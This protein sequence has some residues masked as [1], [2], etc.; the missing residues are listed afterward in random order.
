MHLWVKP[1][2]GTKCTNSSHTITGKKDGFPDE[3]TSDYQFDRQAV[4]H[5]VRGSATDDDPRV[6]GSIQVVVPHL[7]PVQS[8]KF[9]IKLN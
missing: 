7:D 4:L 6:G 8:N 1:S 5:R 2:L 9:S 3:A